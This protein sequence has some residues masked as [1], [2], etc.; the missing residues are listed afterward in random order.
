MTAINL[1]FPWSPTTSAAISL[2]GG[3]Q[4][5]RETFYLL[6]Y[7]F[8]IR[9]YNPGIAR[10][11]RCTGQGTGLQCSLQLCPSPQTCSPA[12][13]LSRPCPVGFFMKTSSPAGGVGS[14]NPHLLGS[15]SHQPPTLGR[16][17]SHLINIRYP[18]CSPHFGHSKGFKSPVTEKE[19]KTK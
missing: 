16:V 9:V 13:K 11:N 3:S 6:G 14:S 7:L 12:W 15:T 1:R 10:W 19:G 5:S 18:H 17:Q 4:N 8:I 2:L